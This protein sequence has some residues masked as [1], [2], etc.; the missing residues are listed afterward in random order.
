M[1]QPDRAFGAGHL[2]AEI[3]AAP[4]RPAHLELTNGARLELDEGNRVVL[5]VDGVHERIRPA[6]HLERAV[7]LPDE[8][9]DD[10]D[11]VAPEI[12]DGSSTRQPAVPEP[13]R[14]RSRMGLPGPDPG[15]VSDRSSIDGGDRL[16][17]LGRVAEI[18]QITGEDPC[19]LDGVENPFGFLGR[20]GQRLRA[21]ALPCRPRPPGRSLLHGGG[22][23]GR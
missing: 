5:I 10:L 1:V 8:V 18:F 20:S 13:G 7:A 12:D 6:H 2:I 16:E 9:A 21:Q 19:L 11:A 14:V 4:E 3:H 17:R 23:A 15:D 22:W